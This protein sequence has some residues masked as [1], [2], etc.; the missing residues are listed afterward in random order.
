MAEI[1]PEQHSCTQKVSESSCLVLH[2]VYLS[3]N[4]ELF[5]K[6]HLQQLLQADLNY[7]VVSSVRLI[8]CLINSVILRTT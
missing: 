6:V 8:I 5:S 3:Q 2:H 4:L 7:F 1:M